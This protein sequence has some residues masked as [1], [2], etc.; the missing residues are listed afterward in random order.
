MQIQS[1]SEIK[2]RVYEGVGETEACGSGTCASAIHGMELGLLDRVVC[3]YPAASSPSAGRVV[4]SA[5]G[6]AG[7]PPQYLTAA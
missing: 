5:Y 3:S 7:L 2:L 6:W 4:T 1:R